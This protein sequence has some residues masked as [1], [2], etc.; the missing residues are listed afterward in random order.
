MA[1]VKSNIYLLNQEITVDTKICRYMDFDAFLQFLSGKLFVPRR[2]IFIDAREGG[3]MPLK[4]KFA[5]RAVGDNIQ[6]SYNI[7]SVN[8]KVIDN[9]IENIRCS[10]FLFTSCWAFDDGEDYLMWKSY[11]SRVGVC[12]KTTVGKL[13]DSIVYDYNKGEDTEHFF[14]ICSNIY[15]RNLYH[16]SDY[17]ESLFT[18]DEYYASEK[19][20]RIYFVPKGK[21][22]D[23]ALMHIDSNENVK[24]ILLDT[25][26]NE[27]KLSESTNGFSMYKFFKIR[28]NCI[29]S[30]V[31]SPF[32]KSSTIECFRDV[33]QN[34]FR[35][36]FPNDSCIKKSSIIIK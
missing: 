18:K 34:Q 15:Y 25:S 26:I 20:I 36:L 23:N 33:L 5:L 1:K 14:P 17:L 16:P 21:I 8:R 30:I 28:P 13:L 12:V 32:I 9:Y 35:E 2:R 4:Y 22:L 6:E 7:D 3:K 19:E 11:T 10:G 24:Q 27:E 31:L 29:D